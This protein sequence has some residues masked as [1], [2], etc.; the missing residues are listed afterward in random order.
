M[1]DEPLIDIKQGRHLLQELCC[2]RFV[3]NGSLLGGEQPKVMVL[4]GPNA[5]GKSIYMKQIALIVYMA[6]LGCFVPAMAGTCIGLT[7]GIFTR[8]QTREATCKQSSAFR[9]DLLQVKKILACADKSSM[10]FIDEFGKGTLPEDGIALFS[11]LIN[12][13]AS[14]GAEAPRTIAITH[15]HEI[16]QQELLAPELPIQW[17]MMECVDST[18]DSPDFTFL[19]RVIEGK[20]GHSLGLEC[21]RAA[22]L[23][24]T[25][26][27][28]AREL[29]E[30]FG[31]G[32]S[33]AAIRYASIDKRF[34]Q[35]CHALVKLLVREEHDAEVISQMKTLAMEIAETTNPI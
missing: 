12:S 18:G 34:D 23:P 15:F 35:A 16:Y 24:T 6:H 2:Q 11:S 19:F 22:G 10:I 4:T 31:S 25:I 27:E 32:M 20:A 21:A 14:R 33:A 9:T 26:I 28:R 17:R 1:V 13:L 29:R 3:P 8:I 5:S 7:T 30:M